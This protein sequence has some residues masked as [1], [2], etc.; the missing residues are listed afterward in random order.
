MDLVVGDALVSGNSVVCVKGAAMGVLSEYA[1][2]ELG[3]ESNG[4][5]VGNSIKIDSL[6]VGYEVAC[7]VAVG[8]EVGRLVIGPGVVR[9]RD[10]G[11]MV[12]EDEIVGWGDGGEVVGEVVGK[13][14]V[15]SA[16]G[17]LV[18]GIDVG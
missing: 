5:D 17:K 12:V 6:N 2:D 8:C 10:I 14:V 16:V 11:S 18:I 15:G 4:I 3:S 9:G 1:G 13:V 7:K